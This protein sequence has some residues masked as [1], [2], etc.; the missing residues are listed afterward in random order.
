MNCRS[1]SSLP[2]RPT[3]QTVCSRPLRG[4]AFD[5]LLDILRKNAREKM[6]KNEKN[7]QREL[8]SHDEGASLRNGSK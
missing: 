3:L 4:C 5:F 6:Q 7:F 8:L 2:V 1:L